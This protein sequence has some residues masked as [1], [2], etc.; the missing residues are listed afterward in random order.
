MMDVVIE[1]HGLEF[2][3]QFHEKMRELNVHL[4]AE[5][6]ART[7][8]WL[9][10]LAE[11]LLSYSHSHALLEL[12]ADELLDLLRRFLDVLAFRKSPLNIASFAVAGGK[13]NYLL[14][15]LA[16]TPFLV[17]SLQMLFQEEDEQASIVSHPIL[18]IDR[19][20]GT[21]VDLRKG[22]GG[23]HHESVMLIDVGRALARKDP[24]LEKIKER[25]LLAR[26]AG[27]AR[28]ILYERLHAMRD[29]EDCIDQTDFIDWLCNGNF[30][31]FGYAALEV[32][33]RGQGM[34]SIAYAEKPV[35]MPCRAI[36]KE[37][38]ISGKVHKLSRNA[39]LRLIRRD[40]ILYEPLEQ[41]SSLHRSE[42]LIYLGFRETLEKGRWRE[43]AFV[44]LFTQVSINALVLHVP[45]LQD[46]VMRALQRQ[47]ILENSYDFRK[48][49]EIFNMFPK[50]ELFFLEDKDL[51][52]LVRS[53]V[54]L[55]RRQAVKVV[56]TRRLS[57][58]D[59]T[60]LVIMPRNFYNPET[61]RR[62][63]NYLGR[64]LKAESVDSRVVHF[65][66]DYLSMQVRVVPQSGQVKIDIDAMERM[67]T[68]LARPWEE[69]LR[70][71]IRR[72]FGKEH[73]DR[74][75]PLYTTGFSKDYKALTHPR[76]AVRDVAAI[77]SMLADEAD[78]FDLWG[79]FHNRENGHAEYYQMQFYSLKE[80]FLNELMPFLEN[81]GLVVASEFDVSLEI[82]GRTAYI[83]SFNVRTAGPAAKPLS[84]IKD[85][86]LDVLH[87]LRNG[88][89]ENDYL[90]QLVIL[91]GLTWKQV[92][93]FRAYRNYYFQLGNP[94]TKSRVAYA[95]INNP[96]I[97]ELLFSYF[98]ARFKPNQAWADPMRREEE[99]LMPVRMDLAGALNAVKDINEDRILRSL[100]N[101][102]DS[103]VRTNF[104]L[105]CD[106]EDYFL[107][108]KISAI[109]IIDMPF[110]RPLY[111]TY[112]HS[113]TMEGI[114]LRGGKVARGGIRWSDRP[115]DFRTEVLGLMKTQMT[116]NAVI[117]PVGSKGGFI[118]KTPFATREE[119][120]ELS[121]A[122]YITLMRGLLDLVDNRVEGEIVHPE[123][124]VVHDDPDPY[125]VVA[126]DKGTA[127]LP[128]TAN[129]VSADYGFW[130]NDA[131]ASGGSQGYDHKKLGITARGAWEC[132]KR[133][134]RELGKDIQSEDFSVVGI[135]DM[136]GDVFGNGMLLSKHIRLLAAFDHRHIFLDPNPDPA[137][138]WKERKRLFDLPRS[139]WEDYNPELIS[140]GGG[141]WSRA[142]KEIP[143]SAEVK[144]MLGLRYASVDG[145][146]LIRA[147]LAADVELLWNGGIGTYVKATT[148]S[149]EE[150]GDKA[151][152]AVRINADQVRAKV[153]G[154]GGNLGLTQRGRIE[155]ALGGGCINTDAVD[156]SAGVDISDHEVNLKIFM[157]FLKEKGVVKTERTRNKVLKEIEEEVCEKV[158]CNNYTQS[159][160]LSLDHLRCGK[161]IDPFIDVADRLVNAGLLDLEGEFLPGRKELTARGQ[162]Y[163]RPELAILMSYSK[164]HLFDAMLKTQLPEQD[165]A[166]PILRNY[167]P[168][169]ISQRYGR[170][171]NQHPLR[172]EIIAT[173]ITNYVVDHAGCAFLNH[174]T[175]QTG[176]TMEQGV[177][178]YLVFDQVLGVG[179][180]RG[181]VFAVD[182]KLAS[183]RQYEILLELESA[184]ASLCA[185]AVELNLPVELES[186][187][188]GH[189]QKKYAQHCGH[190][191]DLLNAEEWQ[192]CK[193]AA[194]DYKSE[195]LDR[196]TAER[197]S[198]LPYLD[199]FL[200]AVQIASEADADLLDVV[201]VLN[202]LQGTLQVPY[203][204]E[205]LDQVMTRN[206]WERLAQTSLRGA[207]R[208]QVVFL[209]RKI[210]ARQQ[211]PA[212][213]LADRRRRFD[214]YREML[215]ALRSAASPGISAFTV[216][217]HA[218]EGLE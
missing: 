45:A 86:L 150:A 214:Y 102:I 157:Q 191:K 215:N 209:A 6:D 39:R 4:E 113:A 117:V 105:R 162:G 190:L 146:T 174:L 114:H 118:V 21:L 144:K 189:Y 72:K 16:D 53:F 198:R 98:E 78:R 70:Q 83:K 49:I 177:K 80:S 92:D 193:Q 120:A 23:G 171:I 89:V 127:H 66:S 28:D 77:E 167:F 122:A 60:L 180:A 156:N 11:S 68:E 163:M 140:A 112:V 161:E 153:I 87:A 91:T 203:L 108:F 55:Q 47:H 95:L 136:S 24:L 1:G 73:A 208:Q 204:L 165:A 69:R 173:M 128:D 20:E 30:I 211:T 61:A 9:R 63:E 99:A 101:L 192:R 29:I 187:C 172:R 52:R 218:M 56:V 201:D 110:P 178:A 142:E 182:N 38:Y 44:G 202:S 58:K 196:E 139:S 79:P 74:L 121:R 104:F 75:N 13:Q 115:D 188:V 109:G 132:V 36:E 96:R 212:A 160:C 64:Y 206:R 107:S 166:Q 17:D 33:K 111:E 195:G 31:C 152:D 81:L 130:L 76:F 35:G 213:Y 141:V 176:A 100:F 65:Y 25:L 26:S 46:K 34:V 131:F 48:V 179:A 40:P 155:Y 197:L 19:Q 186:D 147:I 185:Q 216:L 67:M 106:D 205:S 119:G 2:Q 27:N 103:S 135:G 137:A 116:K 41:R 97:T 158:L 170:H 134:F 168:D 22:G 175:R 37:E 71:Q 94:F 124:I 93:V 59:V 159:L 88:T 181:R 207:V 199:S 51:D 3:E 15:N 50:V 8:A 151:N 148:E 217:L 129:S 145:E 194:K 169:L 42:P 210:I 12:P 126:A 90:N 200:P 154:E 138:T 18:A 133:H 14:A 164:M 82:R 57:L 123:G 85:I 54:T 143:L 183:D 5:P 10:T 43:H 184:L 125:L 84:E 32:E 149:Q 7:S 62:L